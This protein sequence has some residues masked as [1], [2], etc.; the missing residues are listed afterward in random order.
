M[1][2]KDYLELRAGGVSYV[3][4]D[5]MERLSSIEGVVFDCDGVLIDEKT[6]YDE[7]LKEAA[8]ELLKL[9]T[10]FWV[11]SSEISSEAIYRI[12]AVGSFNNDCDTLALLVEW[13]FK[14]LSDRHGNSLVERLSKLRMKDYPELSGILKTESFERLEAGAASGWLEELSRRVS[15]LEGT[16]ATLA[17][18]ESTIGLS[19]ETV[20]EL[21]KA[22]NYPDKYGKSLLTTVFDEVFFGSDL[23]REV[24][25]SGPYFEFEGKLKH[26]KLLV[27]PQTLESLQRRGLVLGMSTGRG[28]WETWRTLGSLSNMFEKQACV[29][30]GDFVAAEPSKKELYEKPSPWSLVKAVK[31]LHR[32][33]YVLYIGNSAEDLIMYKNARKEVDKLVF[34]GVYDNSYDVADYFQENGADLIIPKVNNLPKILDFLEET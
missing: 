16:A 14:M 20:A 34:A 7:A 22:L 1:K 19:S 32:E 23:I 28:S 29:F 9:L 12:R 24:R 21:K 4:F 3:R 25:G 8:S 33:G 2:P 13:L 11:E 26:E 27:E 18:V 17:D 5:S 10:G 31:N 30:I 15:A 6:S